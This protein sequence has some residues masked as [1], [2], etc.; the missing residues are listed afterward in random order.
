MTVT[1]SNMKW[2]SLIGRVSQRCHREDRLLFSSRGPVTPIGRAFIT[3]MATTIRRFAF[4]FIGF[5]WDF[6]L[7]LSD[8]FQLSSS[9][10]ISSAIGFLITRPLVDSFLH[11]YLHT[12]CTQPASLI[13]PQLPVSSSVGYMAEIVYWLRPSFSILLLRLTPATFSSRYVS[14][15]ARWDRFLYVWFSS[16]MNDSF[17]FFFF[18]LLHIFTIASSFFRSQWQ[19]SFSASTDWHR[20]SLEAFTS[21]TT[22][23]I[24]RLI[25][26]FQIGEA[27]AIIDCNAADT[28][29]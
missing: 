21:L 22:S 18:W 26:S 1:N 27:A 29:Q 13:T 28:G 16:S 7:L 8:I 15:H 2:Q 14:F 12:R 24:V 6:R 20:G 5:D 25:T 11:S 17:Y 10:S 4:S 23:V 19:E 9:P 3:T